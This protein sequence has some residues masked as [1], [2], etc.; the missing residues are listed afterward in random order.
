LRSAG[1]EG[2]GDQLRKR[3]GTIRENL[4]RKG[5]GDAR[6]SSAPERVN[7]NKWYWREESPLRPGRKKPLS[8]NEVSFSFLKINQKLGKKK[9][10]RD[11]KKQKIADPNEGKEP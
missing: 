8:P 5:P 4:I 10:S 3:G 9:S 1:G 7:D 6:R 11:K 2:G